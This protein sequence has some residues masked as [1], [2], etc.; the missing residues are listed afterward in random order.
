MVRENVLRS[1]LDPADTEVATVFDDIDSLVGVY[2][3]LRGPLLAAL[4]VETSYAG[5][6]LPPSQMRRVNDQNVL[7]GSVRLQQ[8][9]VAPNRA[10]EVPELFQD[11]NLSSVSIDACFAAWDDSTARDTLPFEGA[12]KAQ[13]LPALCG[14]GAPA[15]GT[16]EC[17]PNVYKWR[18]GAE[19]GSGPF[20]AAETYDG[21]GYVVTLPTGAAEAR[22]GATLEADGLGPSTRAVWI[23]F[24][25]YNV[26]INRFV[27]ARLLFERMASGALILST[28]RSLNLLWYDGSGV[29]L[30]LVPR[31]VCLPLS[32][33]SSTSSCAV[34]REG[35][36]TYW[37]KHP[38]GT[39]GHRSRRLD[40]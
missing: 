34:R 33:S 8:V 35:L 19:A 23:D 6:P 38:T 9:R 17:A 25:L 12:P 28:I 4:Y 13:T 39:I 3:F 21:S 36:A 31:G 27:T 14:P 1:A 22:R 7:V 37:S 2:R 24:A 16:A 40:S 32:S 5:T 26:N 20:G 29:P 10:C 30:L 15:V 11:A 18:A